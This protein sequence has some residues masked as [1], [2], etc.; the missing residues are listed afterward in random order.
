MHV[1]DKEEDVK[2]LRVA[3]IDRR[4]QIPVPSKKKV[5]DWYGKLPRFHG[6]GQP[7]IELNTLSS[8]TAI[9]SCVPYLD[10]MMNGYTVELWTDTQIVIEE[11]GVPN[12]AWLQGPDVAGIRRDRENH[13]ELP[14]PHEHIPYQLTWNLP[15]FF[16]LPEGYSIL[17]THPL[18]RFD[19]PFTTLSGVVD[20][21]K[22]MLPGSFPF[23]LKKGF[24]GFIK[25]GTPICHILPFKRE[26]WQISLDD[27]DLAE[28]GDRRLYEARSVTHG[29]YKENSWSKKEYN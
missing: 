12:I 21:D 25:R 2:K 26:A 19:L 28:R 3:P 1:T 27:G 6:S 20:A 10:A 11:S 8:N 5:P 22:I 24:E 17:V 16:E 23:Y 29:H 18:N 13:P 9:K 7:E 4:L 15:Y 14:V